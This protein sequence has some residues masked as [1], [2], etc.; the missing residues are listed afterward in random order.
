L[1]PG[2]SRYRLLFGLL[3][4]VLALAFVIYTHSLVERLRE[5]G[6]QA[7][8]TIAWFWASAQVPLSEVI[9]DRSR[10]VCSECGTV[11]DIEGVHEDSI[12]N[13]CEYCGRNTW[14]YV[15]S[16]WSDAERE[17]MIGRTRA[18][19]RNLISR[20]DYPTVMTD[21]DMRPQIVNGVAVEDCPPESLRVYTDLV[22]K[23]AATNPP[24]PMTDMAEDTLGWLLYG[25]G[26]LQKE[27]KLVPY[28]ELGILG[29]LGLFFF[30]LLRGELKREKVMAWA[31]FAKE[32]AHQL[33]T[34]ISSLMG[35]LELLGESEA[36]EE[37]PETSEAVEAMRTDV[38]RLGRIADRYGQMGKKPRLRREHVND[39]VSSTVAYFR[40]RPG[41]AD[42]PVEMET[43]LDS[44]RTA[45]VNAV[46]LDWV[47]EN[48]IKNA[49]AAVSDGQGSRI[50]VS[51]ADTEDGGIAITVEDDGKGIPYANQE[52]IFSAG[53]TTRRGGWGLG[54]TLSRRIIE[55]YH[56]GRLRLVVS[57]PGQGSVF[58]ITLP[59]GSGSGEE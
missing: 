3:L 9:R 45:M 26:S 33:S 28:L 41:L 20:L 12:Y 37:D 49:L 55:E 36:A 57:H 29:L 4:L 10:V 17:A 34:P 31:G 44:D 25:S 22:G 56:G 54:L 1:I 23:L 16:R 32:T 8:E 21:E 14:W 48:L 39:V 50:A 19:F 59:S 47:L 11:S 6:R 38:R 58:E 13:Y 15:V 30:L 2:A 42:G 35:W 52:R 5:T 40:R 27:L 7:N 43:H 53:F 24:V 51:T 18:L 46:L